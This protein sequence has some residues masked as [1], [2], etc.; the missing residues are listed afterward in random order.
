MRSRASDGTLFDPTG[1][2]KDLTDSVLRHVGPAFE[3][4]P[5]RVLRLGSLRRTLRGVPCC[6]R[7]SGTLSPHG[8]FGRSGCP[9]A[10]ACVAGAVA[11]ASVRI[12]PSRMLSVLAETGALARVMP[13]LRE[14]E[15]IRDSVDAAARASLPLQARYAL[16]CRISPDG[17]V[18]QGDCAHRRNAPT[19]RDCCLASS[20]API[21]RQQQR[22]SWV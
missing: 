15:Q 18:L 11:R 10:R 2:V 17:R 19:G 4:D 9:G 12:R 21:R 3:E 1:G 22:T 13:E 8:R 5:V 7:D 6:S 16:L 14:D 20:Q